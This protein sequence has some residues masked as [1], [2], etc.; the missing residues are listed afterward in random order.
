MNNLG[1]H[2]AVHM[3]TPKELNFFIDPREFSPPDGVVAAEGT[4]GRGIDWYASHFETH[5]PIRGESSVGY[6]FLWNQRVVDRMYSVVPDARLIFLAR[7]PIDRAISLYRQW[8]AGGQERRRL[9]EAL[10]T[11]PS[12]YIEISRY[13]SVLT[14]YLNKYSRD[15]ILLLRQEELLD[16]RRSTM[17]IVHSFL[18]IDAEYWSDHMDRLHHRS[19]HLARF[20]WATRRFV[21]GNRQ[22]RALPPRIKAASQWM[23]ERRAALRPSGESRGAELEPKLRSRLLALLEDEVAGLE[24]ISGWDLAGWRAK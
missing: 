19:D 15:R 10:L 14:P 6:T 23:L 24:A 4:W 9:G 8:R 17:R 12:P 22:V 5:A 21:F 2:P 18:G 7:D 13:A 3:S 1:L 16:N 20:W 11:E